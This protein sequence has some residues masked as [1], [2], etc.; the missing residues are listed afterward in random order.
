MAPLMAGG[1]GPIPQYLKAAITIAAL[2]ADI[3]SL[4]RARK[5]RS[6]SVNRET[7]MRP[8]P[9][10]SADDCKTPECPPGAKWNSRW[11]KSALASAAIISPFSNADIPGARSDHFVAHWEG[12][13]VFGVRVRSA[14][15]WIPFSIFGRRPVARIQGAIRSQ[16]PANSREGARFREG[17]IILRWIPGAVRGNNV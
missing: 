12:A 2:A 17:F 7:T 3:G 1:G 10:R 9:G 4:E 8:N 5:A 16:V 13:P 6:R 15:E 14:F 11:G